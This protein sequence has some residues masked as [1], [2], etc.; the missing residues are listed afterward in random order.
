MTSRD[1]QL[2]IL[3]PSSFRSTLSRRAMLQLGAGSVGLTALLAACGSDGDKASPSPETSGST[4]STGGSTPAADSILGDYSQVLNQS[5]GTLAMY[6]WGA[7]ND[8]EIVGAQA[9]KDLGVTMKVDYYGS[10]EDLITKL[11]TANGSSGFDVVVPTG[12][13]IPQMIEKGLLDKFDKAKLPN[14]VNVD[15]VYLG[16]TWDP[17]N[18][19]SVCKDWGST[20]WIWDTTKISGDIATWSDFIAACTGEASGNCSV[21]DT[22]VNLLGMYCWANGLDWNT[23]KA[24]DLDAAEKFLVDEFAS[25]IKAFDSYPS[26][27]IAEGAYSISMAWNG[28]ARQ[29]FSRIA[30]AGGNPDDWKWALGAPETE[31]WMDN[32]CIPTGAPNADAA[33]AWINWL[34]SPTISIQDLEYHGYNSGM[35]DMPALIAELAPELVLGDMIFFADDQVATMR[36][37]KITSAQDRIADV[38]NK[39]KAKAGG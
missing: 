16:Q 6:T 27:K 23:E 7:Y 31:L 29:T 3:V 37:Q 5:S 28:D 14:I 30:D 13:Y 8:P 33:H 10:N 9:E 24:E 15:S 2:K 36:T 11:S 38:L 25:H 22:G 35:K 1:E 18:E 17:G 19:Y 4:A 12:P 20:G 39:V 34:L 32:Y 21:L 26:T